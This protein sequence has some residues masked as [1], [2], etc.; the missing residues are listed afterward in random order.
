MA[1][2]RLMYD[3]SDEEWESMSDELQQEISW[4]TLQDAREAMGL[5][6]QED[7]SSNRWRGQDS[8]PEITEN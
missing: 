5:N 8:P 2:D 7:E 1:D 4:N 3:V 6:A